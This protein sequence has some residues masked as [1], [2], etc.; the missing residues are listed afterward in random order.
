VQATLQDP[1]YRNFSYVDLVGGQPVTYDVTGNQLIRVPKL[2]V[3][4]TPSLNLLAGKLRIGADFVHYSDRFA[5]IAN[6]QQLPPFSLINMDVNAKLAD[7]LTL[8]LRATN[9]TNTLGLTEGNPRA[10]SFDVGGMGASYFLA[11][12]EFGRTVR[13]TLSLSY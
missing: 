9:I 12:P 8:V 1:R 7:H 6:T 11:R 4:A 2:A 5:D 10:G 3:R 13:A